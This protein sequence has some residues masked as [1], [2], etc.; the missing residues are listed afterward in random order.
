MK[1]V[2]SA[3]SLLLAVILSV[4]VLTGADCFAQAVDI[5]SV[6]NGNIKTIFKVRNITPVPDDEESTTSG[7]GGIS[8]GTANNRLFVVKS[9][10]NNTYATFY[11]YDNIYDTAYANETKTPLRIVFPK[12]YLAHANSMTV[13]DDYVYISMWKKGGNNYNRIMR[14]SRKYISSVKDRAFVDKIDNTSEY[15]VTLKSGK[16]V[17]FCREFTIKYT[18]GGTYDKSITQIA[19][20]SYDKEKGITKFIITAGKKSDNE[21]YYTIATLKNNAITVE[22]GEYFALL[23]NLSS[24]IITAQDIFY[25]SQYGLYTL[26]YGYNPSTKQGNKTK[27]FIFRY[28]ISSQKTKAKGEVISYR[29]SKAIAIKGDAEIYKTYELESLAFINRDKNKNKLGKPIFIFSSNNAGITPKSI[30]NADS[31]EKITYNSTDQGIIDL[32]SNI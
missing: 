32:Y 21:R 5:H 26:F 22:K 7:M 16:K 12:G 27:N 3:V 14:I 18:D 24:N 31:I 10:P 1:K 13:D 30:G 19:K 25:D 28:N 20:Y 6:A 11:Y 29:P 8:A 4:S 9:S 2:K 15:Q 17:K 23:Q